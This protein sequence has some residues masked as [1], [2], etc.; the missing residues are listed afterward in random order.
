MAILPYSSH[1]VSLATAVGATR[2][3][4]KVDACKLRARTGR[5]DAM[6]EIHRVVSPPTSR[7]RKTEISS[8]LARV[9][10]SSR[11]VRPFCASPG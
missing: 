11:L 2:D 3:Q 6:V 5:R 7:A 4:G 8:F 1:I 9:A 10:R